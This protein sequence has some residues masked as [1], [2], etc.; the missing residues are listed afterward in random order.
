MTMQIATIENGDGVTFPQPGDRLSVHYVG[1]LAGNE[2]VFDSSRDRGQPFEFTL[3]A[4]EVIQGWEAGLPQMSLGELAR[5]VIPSMYGYGKEGVPDVIGPDEDL[6]FDIE[7]LSVN[8]AS[9]QPQPPQQPQQQQQQQPPQQ[10]EPQRAAPREPPKPAQ[11][12]QPQQLNE[13]IDARTGQLIG[14]T[15]NEGRFTPVEERRQPAQAQM[16]PSVAALQDS[17]GQNAV[18]QRVQGA[19][20]TSGSA[21]RPQAGGRS[22]TSSGPPIKNAGPGQSVSQS[23][24]QRISSAQSYSRPQAAPAQM[25]PQYSQPQYSTTKVSYVAP[26]GMAVQNSGSYVPAVTM[27]GAYMPPEM[28]Q[29]RPG[30][31]V[32]LPQGDGQAYRVQQP[33][34]AQMQPTQPS[35]VVRRSYVYQ[36]PMMMDNPGAYV[37]PQGAPVRTGSYVPAPAVGPAYSG[38]VVYSSGGGSYV[39]PPNFG[40]GG[41]SFVPP[42]AYGGGGGSYVPPPAYGGGGRG[43]FV[44]PVQPGPPPPG[45]FGPPPG[46]Y[47][48]PARGFADMPPPYD[49]RDG[50]GFAPPP[51]PD[52]WGDPRKGGFPGAGSFGGPPPADRS[53]A[54][55]VSGSFGGGMDM[56]FRPSPFDGPDFGRDDRPPRYDQPPPRQSFEGGKGGG[57][58]GKGGGFDGKGGGFDRGG[59]FEPPRGR[60][61]YDDGRGGFDPG[62]GG[63]P[64]D[65]PIPPRNSFDQQRGPGGPGP[66]GGPPPPAP[67]DQPGPSWD[68]PPPPPAAPLRPPGY[69]P[70]GQAGGGYP[71]ASYGP[72]DFG[73][74]GFDD[75]FAPQGPPQ[76]YG[77]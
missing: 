62:R 55:P 14:Y 24:A 3:G 17:V 41:G 32:P 8:G 69:G 23:V 26:Q 52:M 63:G 73:R 37:P 11:S 33:M 36:Q 6:M 39:P 72:E 47:P 30:S 71:F 48:A 43:S 19:T 35:Q 64:F 27:N 57:F 58:D 40:G 28:A 9:K 56:G 76:G 16:S 61:P 4:G 54:D 22:E 65:G 60:P 38:P 15:D 53:F 46:Q 44:P 67:W 74:R 49:S 34:Q 10:Q 50:R 66:F 70:S 51:M 1:M 25:Q 31:Y 5:L 12:Q 77:F 59:P 75:R 45:P 2:S 18:R 7:L 20:R 13:C 42:V 29:P 68:F 21:V